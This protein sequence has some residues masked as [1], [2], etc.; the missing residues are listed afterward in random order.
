MDHD[1]HEDTT[2]SPIPC[3]TLVGHFGKPNHCP[4]GTPIES[5][6][7]SVETST[8]EEIDR[9]SLPSPIPAQSHI[10]FVLGNVFFTVFLI[11]LIIFTFFFVV[12]WFTV[13]QD[14]RSITD[15]VPPNNTT[16]VSMCLGHIE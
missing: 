14:A 6:A 2:V 3:S 13:F 16:G 7:R 5:G 8:D 10:H 1:H 11:T 15:R 12:T 4:L 9:I